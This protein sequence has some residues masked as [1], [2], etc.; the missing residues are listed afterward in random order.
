MHEEDKFKS[1]CQIKVTCHA[2]RLK[3]FLTDVKFFQHIS[4]KPHSLLSDHILEIL[5]HT[6][7]ELILCK[8][9]S[10]E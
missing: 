2:Q 4:L 5:L 10:D 3:L 8:Y 1:D 7:T 6:R 9:H